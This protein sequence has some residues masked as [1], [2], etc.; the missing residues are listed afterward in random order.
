MS[1]SPETKNFQLE[2]RHLASSVTLANRSLHHDLGLGIS[3]PSVTI[4]AGMSC[5]QILV[6][7]IAFTLEVRVVEIATCCVQYFEVD[8]Q[9]LDWLT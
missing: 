5:E 4:I 9:Y 1:T 3:E 2:A 6:F 7:E 8:L